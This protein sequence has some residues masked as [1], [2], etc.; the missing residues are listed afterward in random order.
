MPIGMNKC[1]LNTFLAV[2]SILFTFE[3]YLIIG[4]LTD[5]ID[6]PEKNVPLSIIFGITLVTIIY[7]S[8]TIACITVGVGNVY[9]LMN[10]LF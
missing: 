9:D 1:S 7:L 3:G 6:K 8:V 10:V 5:E 2:P 4:N